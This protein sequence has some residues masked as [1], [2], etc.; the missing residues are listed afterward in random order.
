[1]LVRH[2]PVAR[3]TFAAYAEDL[4]PEFDQ[5]PT[6]KYAPVHNIQRVTSQNQACDN[7]HGQTALFLTESD[8]AEDERKANKDVIVREVPQPQ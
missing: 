4:L 1:V 7:C 8:V 3:D 6:W 5:V 2:A